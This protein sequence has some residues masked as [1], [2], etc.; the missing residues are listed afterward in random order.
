MR[1]DTPIYFQTI[2]SEYIA[3][4]GNYGISSVTEKMRYASVTDTGDETLR[5]IYGEI[6]QGC[7][8]IRLQRPYTEPFDRIRIGNKF[9][10][11][12]KVRNLRN[13]QTLIVSEVP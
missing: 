13:I 9:Y 7:K 8:T 6:K 4:S 2:K 12:V 3:S 11:A 10:N 5:L 1:F